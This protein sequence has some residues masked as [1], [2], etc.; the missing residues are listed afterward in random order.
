MRLHDLTL[1]LPSRV[2]IR[3]PKDARNSLAAKNI[4]CESETTGLS[5]QLM[6]ARGPSGS[7]LWAIAEKSIGED[8]CEDQEGTIV[9]QAGPSFTPKKA[10]CHFFLP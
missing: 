3:G 7:S 1:K 8:V 9:S 2:M 5:I 4:A 6:T 10:A